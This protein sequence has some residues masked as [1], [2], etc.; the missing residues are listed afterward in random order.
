[1]LISQ[2]LERNVIFAVPLPSIICIKLSII[3]EILIKNSY[4]L[5]IILPA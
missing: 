1:M 4:E 5:G 3:I 2:Y